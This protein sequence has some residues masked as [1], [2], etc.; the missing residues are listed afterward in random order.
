MSDFN[1]DS[2]KGLDVESGAILFMNED[3]TTPL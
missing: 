1:G 2:V 3:C